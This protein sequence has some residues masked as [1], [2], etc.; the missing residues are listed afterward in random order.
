[1]NSSY[2]KNGSKCSCYLPQS[3]VNHPEAD[4]DPE[5]HPLSW[6]EKAAEQTA[7]LINHIHW[8]L[9]KQ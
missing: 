6:P 9:A 3:I 1:M 2:L 7:E 5:T 8:A 4:T